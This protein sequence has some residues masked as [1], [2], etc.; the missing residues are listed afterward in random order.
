M[1]RVRVER[2]TKAELRAAIRWYDD[3]SPGLGSQLHAEI[4]VGMALL[5]RLPDGSTPVPGVPLALG[6]RRVFI[7]RF[8]YTI[9]F[10]VRDGTVDVIAFAHAKRRPGYWLSRIGSP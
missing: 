5:A 9:V 10:L 8:P 4:E 3:Q 2:A 6:V 7:K 1:R